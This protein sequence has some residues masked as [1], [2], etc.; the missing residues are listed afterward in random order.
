M[1]V[2]WRLGEDRWIYESLGEWVSSRTTERVCRS[3]Y[4]QK[5]FADVSNTH[6]KTVLFV[7]VFLECVRVPS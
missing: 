5:Q 3:G 6:L 1:G 4:E 2:G 7:H